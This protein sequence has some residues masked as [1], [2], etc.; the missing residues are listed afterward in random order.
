MDVVGGA[1]S[2]REH[3]NIPS[4]EKANTTEEIRHAALSYLRTHRNWYARWSSFYSIAWNISTLLVVVLGASTSILAASGDVLPKDVRVLV[5]VLPAIS[6]LLAALLIQFKLREMCHLREM[7]RLAC[8][9]LI[10]KAYRIS[11]DHEPRS[12]LELAIHL[13]EAAHQLERNQ[14]AEFMS[15]R[16]APVAA[17]PTGNPKWLTSPF[18]SVDNRPDG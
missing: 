4:L 12:A 10:C 17:V 3:A 6:S 18:E 14:L 15:E 5:I 13:R 1:M 16:W 7:G 9:D 8:E 2:F 11:P